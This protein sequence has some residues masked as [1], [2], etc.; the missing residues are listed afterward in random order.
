MQATASGPVLR[1]GRLYTEQESLAGGLSREGSFAEQRRPG[2][3]GLQV[4]VKEDWVGGSGPA[5]HPLADGE[6][7]GEEG[8]EEEEYEGMYPGN[9]SSDGYSDVEEGRP[10]RGTE[11]VFV[12]EGVC[13]WPAADRRGQR[14]SG[15]LSLIKQSGCLF[16]CWLPYAG[17]AAEAEHGG[18]GVGS[19]SSGRQPGGGGR[20]G[21][22]PGGCG[23]S[24]AGEGEGGSG[25]SLYAVHPIPLSDIKALRKHTPALG[26]HHVTLTLATGVSLPSFFFQHG[27][28]KAFLSCLREHACL[29]RSADDPST[30]LINDT[31]DPLQRSLYSLELLGPVGRP[32]L[33]G[34]SLAGLSSAGGQW[35]LADGDGGLRAQLSELVD[36]FQQLTQSARNTA[37]SLL[38]GSALLGGGGG[39]TLPGPHGSGSGAPAGAGASAGGSPLASQQVPQ[40]QAP[41]GQQQQGQLLLRRRSLEGASTG[42]GVF[43]LLEGGAGCGGSPC[44][45][46]RPRPPP[47]TLAELRSFC[48]RDG[49]LLNPAAFRQRVADGGVEPEGRPEAWKLLLGVNM[50]EWSAAQRA[51]RQEERRGAY[52]RLRLQWSNIGRE[53]AARCSKWRERR[54]RIEKDVRRTDRAHRFYAHER[55]QAHAMLA[56]VLLTYE[57]YNQ[58]LGYVQGMSDLLAPILYVVASNAPRGSGGSHQLDAPVALG[59]EA[60]A[61]WAFEAL[62]R[63]MEPNFSSDS[64]VMH[65]QLGAL[66]DLLALLDPPLHAHLAARDCLSLFFCYRW[67]LLHFKREFTFD[68]VLCLWEAL[69]AGPPGLHLYLCVAVLMRH[70]RIIL[71]HNWRFDEMLQWAVGLA[72]KLRLEELLRDAER[73]AAAAGAAGRDVLAALEAGDGGGGGG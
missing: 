40:Q 59:V 24:A 13:V 20:A 43:E 25:H 53:Q 12:K 6:A 2:G 50:P 58:D 55:S 65:A 60:E 21:K 36:R 48:D 31:A 17:G 72:G 27:G 4:V 29:V 30:Y 26:P 61:F 10:G 1:E 57:R 3:D 19:G 68:E 42:V 16:L 35:A 64:R 44:W 33:A 45:R 41:Q 49:R 9:E 73:L 32:S 7:E 47:L 14:I 18:S 38:A 67:L 8:L 70:R 22:Q 54:S 5:S 69:W 11:V 71:G 51:Q 56:H 37:S 15:R 34:A 23:R 66:R 52:R 62:M 39:A 63:R 46:E 28:V